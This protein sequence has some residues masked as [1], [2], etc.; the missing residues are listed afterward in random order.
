MVADIELNVAQSIAAVLFDKDGTL[1]GYDASWGPVNRELASI[2]AK[3]DP[4]L[5]DRLLSACGMDPVTGHVVP[6]S[7]LAAGN[8]AE[9]AA[10]LVAAGSPCDVVELTQRLDRLFTEAADKS[11]PVTDLKGFREAEGSRLQARY[12]LQRQRKLHPP[13]GHPLRFRKRYRFRC[14]I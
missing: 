14:G 5:A 3:G 10:G 7:L 8:T 9:I 2:A 12:R 13:D 1:L 6:D 4:V 11:V